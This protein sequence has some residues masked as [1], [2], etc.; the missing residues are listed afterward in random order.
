MRPVAAAAV[1]ATPDIFQLHVDTRAR[2]QVMLSAEPLPE[3][4]AAPGGIR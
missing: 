1:Q 4:G 3:L 2:A